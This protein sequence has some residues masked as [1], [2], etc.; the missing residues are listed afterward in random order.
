MLPYGVS[1]F[2]DD[3]RFEQQNKFSLIGCY[4]PEL[5]LFQK[6]P[7]VLPK[8][9]ILVQIRT[10]PERYPAIK[11]IVYPPG[12]EEPLFLHEQEEEKQDFQISKE[13]QDT[14]EEIQP[15]RAILVPLMFAPF[16]I[17]NSGFI[18]VRLHYGPEIIR[19]GALQIKYQEQPVIGSP[20]LLTGGL[21]P[22]G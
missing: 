12:R 18:R 22:Q 9:C 17:E 4:G 11:I 7:V 2:C 15:Q 19:I 13:I 8:L 5:I 20:T 3:I 21:V 16:I 6:P 10:A 1:Y 14:K